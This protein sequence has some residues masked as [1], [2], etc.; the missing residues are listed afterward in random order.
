MVDDVPHDG[1]VPEVPMLPPAPG[2]EEPMIDEANGAVEDIAADITANEIY[3]PEPE[4]KFLP[5]R[6]RPFDPATYHPH[7]HAM[8]LGNMLR[9]KDFTQGTPKDF[10][11][12]ERA[13]HLSHDTSKCFGGDV[14]G[15]HQLLLFSST[16]KMTITPYDFSMIT[17][18]RIGGDPIPFDIDMGQWEAAWISLLRARPPLDRLAMVRW[19]TV[20]LYIL[21]A[22]VVLPQVHFYDWGGTALASLYGFMSSDSGKKGNKVG[23]YCRV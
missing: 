16:G 19:N 10:L 14:V 5:L 18:L 8:A 6:V 9:F 21:S 1:A 11:L 3:P 22:L 13:S 23:G 4:P 20:G 15:H 12:R 2:V 17:G 7:T